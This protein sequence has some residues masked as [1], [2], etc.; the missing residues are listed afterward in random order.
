MFWFHRDCWPGQHRQSAFSRQ[1]ALGG[2]GQA[3]VLPVLGGYAW[4]QVRKRKVGWQISIR[5]VAGQPEL[6]RPRRFHKCKVYSCAKKRVAFGLV[7]LS[8]SSE[9]ARR[10][11]PDFADLRFSLRP[12]TGETKRAEQERA[13]RK[14]S[15]TD[16]PHMKTEG[17]LRKS[18]GGRRIRA[19]KG[20]FATSTTKVSHLG[21]SE[22]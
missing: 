15:D 4:Q 13:W 21:L 17:R 5:F 1:W 14:H 11:N 3:E 18:K 9:R 20:G 22:G 19:V 12:Q 16:M 6:L 8:G 10:A 7:W 2:S